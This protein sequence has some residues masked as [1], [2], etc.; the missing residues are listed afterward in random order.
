MERK[1]PPPGY[2]ADV[3]Q[4]KGDAGASV[5][6]YVKRKTIGKADGEMD[7]EEGRCRRRVRK[8]FERTCGSIY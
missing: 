2:F 1:V 4:K 3:C 6:M 8:E 7:R 5:R